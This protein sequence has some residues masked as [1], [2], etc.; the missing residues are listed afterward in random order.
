MEI[1][2]KSIKVY[3]I[4]FILFVVL[5]SILAA[6]ICFTGFKESWG[7]VGIITVLGISSAVAG[8]LE[9]KVAGSRALFV[10]LISAAVFAATIYFLVSVIFSAAPAD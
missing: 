4:A 5:T 8:V 10:F 7:Y 9:A 1:I 6:L 2:R 3:I